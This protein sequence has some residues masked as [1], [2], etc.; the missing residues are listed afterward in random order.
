MAWRVVNGGLA[1]AF[2]SLPG[3]FL[4]GFGFGGKRHGRNIHFAGNPGLL[5]LHIPGGKLPGSCGA[6]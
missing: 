3:P 4:A 6:S 1:A 5:H 2:A